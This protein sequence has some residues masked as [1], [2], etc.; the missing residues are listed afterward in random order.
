[1]SSPFSRLRDKSSLDNLEKG[2]H[3]LEGTHPTLL[4]PPIVPPSGSLLPTSEV[5]FHW[6]PG[7]DA[8]VERKLA[9]AKQIRQ[10]CD[11][12]LAQLQ[13]RMV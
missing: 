8:E 12:V 13:N 7:P 4:T 3:S 2:K 10:E 1:M 6:Q 9:R 5:P 11:A